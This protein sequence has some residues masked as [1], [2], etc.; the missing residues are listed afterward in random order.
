MITEPWNFNTSLLTG[1]NKGQ[2]WINLDLVVV[3]DQR[4]KFG[5]MALRSL[6]C[7]LMS[8]RLLFGPQESPRGAVLG[9]FFAAHSA[10]PFG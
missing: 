7:R 10:I 8:G 6:R 5:H 9:Y 2:G 3:N 1:L 4:A